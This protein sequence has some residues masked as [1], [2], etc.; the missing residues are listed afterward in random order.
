[1]TRVLLTALIHR[2]LLLGGAWLALTSAALDA[3]A[4]GAVA[5]AV[6]VWL[7]LRLLPP[8][9]P[10]AL[11]RLARHVPRFVAG[12]VVGGVDVARRAV[13]PDMRLKPGWIEIPNALPDGA[14]VVLG[15][16]LSLMPGT[17]S[18]GTEDGKL[19]VHL[20]DTDAGFDNAM[21]REAEEIAAIIGQAR[22]ARG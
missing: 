9:H 8:K 19:L 11:W 17:L 16:E 22:S 5:V 7:S 12:S 10:F 18:A 2:A 20:L 14:R 13:S 6:A 21:P 3:L 15:G 4:P 1:M